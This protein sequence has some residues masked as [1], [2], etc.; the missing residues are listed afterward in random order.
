ME[1]TGELINSAITAC[2]ETE[3]SQFEDMSQQFDPLQQVPQSLQETGEYIQQNVKEHVQETAEEH[4]Q[5]TAEGHV[6]ESV[7]EHIQESAEDHVQETAR[8]E[9]LLIPINPIDVI[10]QLEKPSSSPRKKARGQVNKKKPRQTKKL[11][12][13]TGIFKIPSQITITPTKTQQEILNPL[14]KPGN[15]KKKQ[16]FITTNHLML[17]KPHEKPILGTEFQPS[18]NQVRF[19]KI[20]YL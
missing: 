10:N 6:Q 13:L 18:F 8:T 11:V 3:N 17:Q 4:V 19:L 12:P 15:T 1:M 2:Y 20:Y 9:E 14:R 16:N 7:I 5:E